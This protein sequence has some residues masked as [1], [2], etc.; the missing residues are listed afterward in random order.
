AVEDHLSRRHLQAQPVEQAAQGVLI[1]QVDAGAEGGERHGPI[2]GT[3]VGGP[4][5][6]AAGEST[7]GA[8]LSRPRPT[9]NADDHAYRAARSALIE[10]GGIPGAGGKGQA[11]KNPTPHPPPRRGEGEK[12]CLLPLSPPGRGVGGWGNEVREAVTA[13][14][15]V[16]SIDDREDIVLGHDEVLL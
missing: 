7:R 15:A 5:A 12:D 14:Y 9:V 16:R 8:G 4:E 2:H 6:E 10:N 1:V 3:R 11:Q 13:P